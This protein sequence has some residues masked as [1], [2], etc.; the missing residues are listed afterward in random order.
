MGEVATGLGEVDGDG[1][2]W[3]RILRNTEKEHCPK[4]CCISIYSHFQKWRNFQETLGPLQMSI[5]NV[6]FVKQKQKAIKRE[7]V[8]YSDTLRN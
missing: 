1:G 6:L 4:L 8:E 7:Q 5:K 3:D 2:S